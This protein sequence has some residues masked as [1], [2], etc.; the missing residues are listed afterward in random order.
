MYRRISLISAAEVT[1]YSHHMFPQVQ[2]SMQLR[3]FLH[4][5]LQGAKLNI[6]YEMY[7]QDE[8][9]ELWDDKFQT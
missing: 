2:L 3:I 6:V 9:S 4:P 7:C 8:R 1:H 5:I